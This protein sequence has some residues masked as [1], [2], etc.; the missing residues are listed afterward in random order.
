ME[1]YV[2]DIPSRSVFWLEKLDHVPIENVI[3]G[4]RVS[5]KVDLAGG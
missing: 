4:V 1:N 5:R 3:R 2:C